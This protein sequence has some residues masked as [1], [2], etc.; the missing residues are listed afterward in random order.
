M[1]AYAFIASL[2]TMIITSSGGAAYLSGEFQTAIQ[3]TQE[4]SLKIGVL[5]EQQAKYQVRKEQIDKQIA[6]LPEKTSVT[7]RLRL[8]N[9]FKAEQ[10]D[11]SN[12]IS[13]LDK[14]LPSL[15]VNQIMSDAK[16]G[17]VVYIAKA[18][19]T[20][21]EVVVK[22]VIGLITIVFDPLAVFLIIA[23]N[24]LI[25]QRR[26]RLAKEPVKVKEHNTSFMDD[27]KLTAKAMSEPEVSPP[28]HLPFDETNTSFDFP[29]LKPWP[30]LV[31]AVEPPEAPPAPVQSSP[32][33][34]PEVTE[35]IPS[36]PEDTPEE[37][38]PESEPEP[39]I[40]PPA[41]A[42]LPEQLKFTVPRRPKA[43][44]PR[45]EITLKDLKPAGPVITPHQSSLNDVRADDSVVFETNPSNVLVKYNQ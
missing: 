29:E 11:L 17:P 5:K 25:A 28:A 24:F 19:N 3:G 36:T 30:S 8:M 44:A 38:A 35:A 32:P 13:E 14:Q 12:K 16:A 23:G 22:Y 43:P 7:Q 39:V 40:E 9:G 27:L 26:L 2:V 15:Q 21:P 34:V 6:S 18:F 42:P 45:A 41:P 1:K 33:S 31:T 10:Q 37:P 4:N 20:T